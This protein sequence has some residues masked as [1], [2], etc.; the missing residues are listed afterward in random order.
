MT[1]TSTAQPAPTAPLDPSR[2]DVSTPGTRRIERT[3]PT[4]GRAGTPVECADAQ[5]VDAAVRAAAA[6]W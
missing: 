6:A 5:E 1:S 4:T 2:A 3:D